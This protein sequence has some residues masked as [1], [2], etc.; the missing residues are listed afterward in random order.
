M[1]M[2]HSSLDQYIT[3][4]PSASPAILPLLVKLPDLAISCHIGTYLPTAGHEE[5]FLTAL[6]E[7]DT[8]I[9]SVLER[10]G[11]DTVVYIRGDMNVSDKNSSRTPLLSHIMTKHS[12]TRVSLLHPSYHHFIGEG[13]EF[14]SHLDV[15]LHSS[16][17]AV[18]E[19]LEEQICKKEHP[20]VNSHHDLLVSKAFLPKISTPTPTMAVPI[21]PKI[22]NQRVKIKWSES[23]ISDYQ[24][25]IGPCCLS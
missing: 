24:T 9:S 17:S 7:I 13:G 3:V 8:T 21:A 5:Q 23:G 25:I 18:R 22:T 12:L 6:S 16:Q 1:A 15:L 11:E 20:L 14:D 2:W 10:F 19:I 4:L